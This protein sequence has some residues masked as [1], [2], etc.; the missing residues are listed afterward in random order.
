MRKAFTLIE[1]LVVIAIVAILAGV[2]FPVFARAKEAA[3]KTACVSNLRQFSVG[4]LLY[5]T[6]YDEYFHKGADNR[7]SAQYGFGPHSD[8]DGW[9]EWPWFYGPYTKTA[10][11][12]DCP[13]SPDG[14]TQLTASNWGN[15][16]NYGYNYS[17]LTRDQ[18]TPG[19]STS[20][21]ED[22]S[23]TFAFFDSGDP[24]VRAGTN[25]WS[26]L[27]EELDLNLNCDDNRWTNGYSKE[28]ALRHSK[29]AN[30]VFTDGHVKSTTWTTLLTRKGD[31]VA[32]WMISWA[33]CPGDCPPPVV[34]PGQC[35]DPGRLP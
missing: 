15:D 22:G 25:N 10:A 8:L 19:R 11:I 28:A 23:F 26:G 30:M 13:I 29:Q 6:D 16:G 33:D 24:A 31:N 7:S 4:M 20:E 32:P 12:F 2:L 34:G 9:A 21:L 5:V 17:G 14:M 27:L 18:G 1:I 35:F 3:K